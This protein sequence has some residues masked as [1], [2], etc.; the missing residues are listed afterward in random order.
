[1]EQGAEQ[2]AFP[3]PVATPQCWT[4]PELA[5]E[6]ERWNWRLAPEEVAEIEAAVERQRDTPILELARDPLPGL[7]GR[8]AAIRREVLHGIGFQRI[9]G[10]PVRDWPVERA[11]AAFWLLGLHLGEA[12]SQNGKGHVLGHVRDLGL[13]YRRPETRGYQTRARLPFHTDS[14]D[15][16]CL[17]CLSSA[18]EGGESSLVSSVAIWNEMARRRPDL[19][20]AL[21]RPLARTRWGEV[22]AGRRPWA[23]V[24]VFKPWQGN[25]VTTYVRSA[26]EKAR[27]MPGA[28]ALEPAQIEAMDTID[29]LA[30]DPALHLDMVLEEGDIQIVN[31]HRILHSRTAYLDW[32]DPARKRHLLRL[33]LA[34]EDGPALPPMMTDEYQEAT[35]SGRPNGIRVPGVAFSAPLAAE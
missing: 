33:W 15:L 26:I 35:A 32:E 1:M 14:S 5:A 30:A 2:G 18:R 9:R 19:A 7:A 4:G 29:A 3:E 17:L 12:V 11:A 22:P 16:A 21:T 13:D 8:L 27:A 20:A 6:P 34:C 28:P 31:N 24:P 23:E 10:L 25:V